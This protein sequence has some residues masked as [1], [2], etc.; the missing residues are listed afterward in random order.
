MKPLVRILA[1]VINENG[2]PKG[3]QEFE[4]RIDSDDAMYINVEEV[5][6]NIL[7]ETSKDWAETFTYLSHELIFHDPVIVEDALVEKAMK[8]VPW[9]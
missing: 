7:K 5:C 8:G 6:K 3:G 1:Q 4:F 2:K 9:E